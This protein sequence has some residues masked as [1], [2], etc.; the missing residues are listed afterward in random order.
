MAV[1]RATAIEPRGAHGTRQRQLAQSTRWSTLVLTPEAKL[2][3][4]TDS[5]AVPGWAALE[6]L[7]STKCDELDGICHKTILISC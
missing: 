7:Q 3:I 5:S 1:F 6:A 4:A 2:K